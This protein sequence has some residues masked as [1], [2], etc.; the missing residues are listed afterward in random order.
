MVIPGP[1]NYD[2]QLLGLHRDHSRAFQLNTYVYPVLSRRSRGLSVGINLNPDKAC[3]FDCVYCQVNRRVPSIV[4]DVDPALVVRE[5]DEMLDLVESGAI[6]QYERFSGVPPSLLR[7]SDI[8]FSGDGEPTSCPEFLRVV[9]DVAELKRRRELN[10]VKLVLI[11]N[12]TLLDRP[13]VRQALA[14][15]DANK[16]EVWAKLDAGTPEYF[17]LIDRTKVP[18]EKVLANILDAA[19][20]R[21]IVI[22]GL[23]MTLA[24]RPADDAEIDAYCR[25]LAEILA[26]GG[27]IRSVQVYTVARPPAEESVGP[28]STAGLERIAGRVRER[29]GLEVEVFG[30]GCAAP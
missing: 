24:G 21:P 5:L 1:P 15:L 6:Y 13:P 16:G 22:Q 18:F 29:I 25:R 14:I 23:F 8:A 7:L 12:A 20:A 10:R 28:L 4:R 19:R 17:R 3:N 27:A 9:T 26:G 2:P 30:G 11:T